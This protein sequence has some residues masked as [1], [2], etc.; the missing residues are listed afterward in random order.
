MA[1]SPG[2]SPRQN[3][4]RLQDLGRTIETLRIARGVSKRQLAK[5][6][7]VDQSHLGKF[8]KG[9]AGLSVE[10]MLN[11]LQVLEA[12]MAI[13]RGEADDRP[14]VGT[15]GAKGRVAF[16]NGAVT[17]PGA[18]RIDVDAGPFK[19]GDTVVYEPGEWA[20]GRYA[21]VEHE[22][23]DWRVHHCELR[24]GLQFLVTTEATLYD[25]DVHT[26]LGLAVERRSRL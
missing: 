4:P 8:I 23:G 13:E 17:M 7:G 6:S 14:L 5:R 20:D 21:I 25:P 1:R 18:F 12:G 10:Q 11:V 2:S 15:I 26:I 9:T 24:S 16:F 19:A 22:P 3:D